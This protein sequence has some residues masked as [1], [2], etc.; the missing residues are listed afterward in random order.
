MDRDEVI[1]RLKSCE[2]TLRQRGVAHVALFG[3]TARREARLDSDIDLLV[4]LAPNT[5]MGLF[6]Y[7]ALVQFL[8]DLFPLRVEVVNGR[9]VKSEIRQTIEGDA[10]YAF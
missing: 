5:G 8:E 3:S 4:E 6:E 9:K 2:T 10:L 1:E 7:S